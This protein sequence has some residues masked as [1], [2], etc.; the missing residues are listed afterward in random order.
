MLARDAFSSAGVGV[1]GTLVA[2]GRP[3]RSEATTATTLNRAQA[4][5]LTPGTSIELAPSSTRF[6]HISVRDGMLVFDGARSTQDGTLS[7]AFNGNA[8]SVPI[9]KGDRASKTTQLMEDQVKK[10]GGYTISV[11]GTMTERYQKTG[12]LPTLTTQYE[13]LLRSNAEVFKDGTAMEFSLS[14]YPKAVLDDWL[15]TW[16]ARGTIIECWA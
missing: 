12:A 3:M 14:R 16:A 11:S 7:F 4:L 15:A 1:G 5:G 10:K 9:K 2:R 13:T 8:I 6:D